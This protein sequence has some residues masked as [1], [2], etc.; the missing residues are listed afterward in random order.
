MSHGGEIKMKRVA[1]RT[2]YV[3]RETYYCLFENGKGGLKK[4]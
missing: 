4:Q 3:V 1:L 2:E